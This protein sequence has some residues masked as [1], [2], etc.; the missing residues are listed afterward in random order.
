MQKTKQRLLTGNKAIAEAIRLEMERDPN[1]FV[2]GEDVGVYGGIFGA[3]E[4]LFQQFGPERVIDTPISETAFIGAAIGAAAEGMR[5]IV[6][7]MF[8]DFFG[9]CM[10]QI[11]NHMAKIPYMSGGRVKLPMVLMTAVG[12]G[13]SDA[14]QHSQT[15]YATFAHLPGMKVVAPSTPYDL[16]GMMI[17]AI[18]DDNPVVFMF[19]KTLQG[20]GWMDQLDASVGHV[21]EEAYTV[22]IGKAKVVR[23]GTDITIVGIQMTTH[24]ALEA[25]KKLEQHGI[26]AEVIDLRS[27]VPLDR[28]TILQSIKKTHRLLVV[29]EDY[30][31]YGM[32]AEIAAIAA[33]EGLYDLDAPVRRLAVPDVPIPYSRPLEQFVLPNADKIFN[34]AM[35]LVNE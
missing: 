5:P 4:G 28:E 10:D 20:L 25:A 18:R 15:L 11:Y 27:L 8:V 2:M 14:A 6:E 32:T 29:D 26:Q 22:P 7:L 23:E 33:E 17:S 35:K 9:V 1:V 31:S 19:H 12:G 30:L 21:P 24:H 16:K 3:T 13:Y 34:E